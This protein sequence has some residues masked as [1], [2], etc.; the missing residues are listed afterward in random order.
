MDLAR[1]RIE[2]AFYA[3]TLPSI[4]AKPFDVTHN[5]GPVRD[6]DCAAI[7]PNS[8]GETHLGWLGHS[9]RLGIRLS[10]RAD[11]KTDDEKGSKHNQ[12]FQTNLHGAAIAA[13]ES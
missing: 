1:N 11:G 6:Q 7:F 10:Y 8:A 12:S 2:Q 4:V 9:L 3:Y 13:T 5:P